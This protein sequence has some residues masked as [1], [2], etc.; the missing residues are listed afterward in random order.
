MDE[1]IRRLRTEAQR[2]AQGKARSQVRYAAAFRRAAVT[3]RGQV[4]AGVD[5]WRAWRATSACR[6]RP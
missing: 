2:L 6:N 4:T 3:W 5:P 1:A